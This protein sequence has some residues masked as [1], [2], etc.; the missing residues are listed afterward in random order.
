MSALANT[1]LYK[2]THQLASPS[3]FKWMPDPLVFALF[4]CLAIAPTPKAQI[5][6]VHLILYPAILRWRRGGGEGLHV[7]VPHWCTLVVAIKF[8]PLAGSYVNGCV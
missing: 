6:R 4:P 5:P 1:R 3:G 7:L 8:T 2:W